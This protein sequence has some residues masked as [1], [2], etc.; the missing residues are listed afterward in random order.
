MVPEGRRMMH[1]GA[2]M[3]LA[4]IVYAVLADVTVG[5][6]VASTDTA[7]TADSP[8]ASADPT[9]LAEDSPDMSAEPEL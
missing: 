2:R 1:H 7:A 6:A 5:A 4:Q 9:L 3:V 8:N